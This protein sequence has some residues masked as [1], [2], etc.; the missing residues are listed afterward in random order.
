MLTHKH[1]EDGNYERYSEDEL[2]ESDDGDFDIWG[3]KIE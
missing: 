1:K 2:T 3:K